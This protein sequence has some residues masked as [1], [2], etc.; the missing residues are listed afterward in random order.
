MKKTEIRRIMEHIKTLGNT[1]YVYGWGSCVYA[2]FDE[3]DI[4]Y[5]FRPEGNRYFVSHCGLGKGCIFT[6]EEEYEI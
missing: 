3:D 2:R 1:S 4:I 5:R 6:K